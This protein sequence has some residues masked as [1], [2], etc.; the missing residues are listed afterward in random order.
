LSATV[1][2]WITALFPDSVWLMSLAQATHALNFA[3]F[4]AAAM[5]LLAQYFPG[6]MNG[7]G[8]GVFY[9]FSSGV[10]GVVGALLAGQLWTVGGGQL[11]FQVGG[12]T[13][14]VAA[15]IAGTKLRPPVQ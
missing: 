14:L 10:G 6:R 15:L 5:H 12:T 7:H 1:R 9:G 2:W 11:A 13:C 4:F 3:G 8:Q